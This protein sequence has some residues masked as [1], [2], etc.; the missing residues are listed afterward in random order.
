MYARKS[1]HNEGWDGDTF[2]THNMVITTLLIEHGYTIKN[3]EATTDKLRMFVFEGDDQMRDIVNDFWANKKFYISPK[4]FVTTLNE[5]R[6]QV[7][8][9]YTR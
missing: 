1:L 7:K 2:C 8:T 6:S 9:Q 3:I 5:V 4:S